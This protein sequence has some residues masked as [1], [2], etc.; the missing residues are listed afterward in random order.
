MSYEEFVRLLRSASVTAVADVRSTP[1][2]RRNPQFN[3]DTLRE[4]LRMDGIAYVFLGEELGGRPKERQYFCDGVADY[5][6]MAKSSDFERGLRRVFEGSKQYRVALMCS[7]HD[8]LEC[9]RCLLVGRA[10]HERGA[11]V[12]HILPNQLFLDQAEVER[13]LV[14]LSRHD[15]ADL[16]QS[17]RERVAE[18]YR[19]RANKVAYSEPTSGYRPSPRHPD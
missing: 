10:L 18:A 11:T 2:S 8:P 12:R 14:Q 3:R 19:K 4:E 9:H 1:F 5:E 7:E 17:Y 15:A 13:R 16:F 6:K